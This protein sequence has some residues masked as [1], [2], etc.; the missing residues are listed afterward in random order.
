MLCAPSSKH[1]SFSRGS[2]DA[3][4]SEILSL[5]LD[6]CR[7]DPGRLHLAKQ[8]D[9]LIHLLS[10]LHTG[11]PRVQR[12][13]INML[14]HLFP[15]IDPSRVAALLGIKVSADGA[16]VESRRGSSPDFDLHEDGL[17][18]ILLSCVA[19]ALNVQTKVKGMSSAVCSSVSHSGASSITSSP[20]HGPVAGHTKNMATVTLATSIHPKDDLRNRWFMK[21]CMSRSTAE[22]LI[23]LLKDMAAGRI[24][25]KWS[26][27]AGD[28]IMQ[29]ILNLTRLRE[30]FRCPAECMRTPTLWLALASLCVM[31][32]KQADRLSN[33]MPTASLSSGDQCLTPHPSSNHRVSHSSSK[34][35]LRVR[36]KLAAC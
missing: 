11:S 1:S 7:T 30:E 20:Y 5:L 14:R 2:D 32:E 4:A 8:D 28:C 9:L 15:L 21:G 24:G 23:S 18:D 19:K 34:R 16:T 27:V 17:L 22:L 3:F 13:V 36:E 6:L 31:D 33:C 10:L 29:N 35:E 12:D 25:E 26:V